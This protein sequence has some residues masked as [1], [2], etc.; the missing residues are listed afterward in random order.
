MWQNIRG[1]DTIVEQFRRAFQRGRLTGSY[2]FVGPSGVGK[3]RFAFALAMG[4]LCKKKDDLNPCGVCDSCKLFGGIGST[5]FDF[6]TGEFLSPHPDLYYVAKPANKSKLPLELLIGSKEQRGRTGLCYN[7]S[8]TPFYNNGKVAIIND[9][10]Y[11]NDEGA[12][13]LLKTL[14][15]P[16]ADSV[17]ILIGTTTAGQL[18][19]IRSR[20]QI[21][22]FSPLPT[23]VLSALLVDKGLATSAEQGEKWALQAEGSLDRA[24]ELA[25]SDIDSLRTELVKQLTAPHWNAVT[26][27]A[28]MQEWIGTAEKGAS[29][30]QLLRQ[31]FGLAVNHFRNE[32]LSENSRR[33]ARRLERTL[34]ALTHVD[35]NANLPLVIEAWSI[36][37]GGS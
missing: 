20:C 6:D 13:A 24:K 22:R 7:I 33:A 9:A 1:H 28:R 37:L 12:N 3:R 31:I 14:E 35:R 5:D 19:T 29:Q 34:D 2:L 17:L 4:L 11:F 18:P 21:V 36:E 16:P 8:R 10:D 23:D 27:A 15:E 26:L 30:R 32:L 25:D